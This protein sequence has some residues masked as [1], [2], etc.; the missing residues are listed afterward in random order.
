MFVNKPLC[1]KKYLDAFTQKIIAMTPQVRQ[2]FFYGRW[3]QAKQ[4]TQPN[5]R[6]IDWSNKADRTIKFKHT[7]STIEII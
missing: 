6:G 2:E 5:W 3:V 1:K 4:K 7:G